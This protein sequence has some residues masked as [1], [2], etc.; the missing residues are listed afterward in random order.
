MVDALMREVDRMLG[1]VPLADRP[2]R[3]SELEAELEMLQRQALAL[4]A[5]LTDDFQP[6]VVL[7]VRV[8]EA[9]RASRAA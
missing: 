5:E 4:G 7:G 8:A 6:P 3:I 9:K 2:K 1:P